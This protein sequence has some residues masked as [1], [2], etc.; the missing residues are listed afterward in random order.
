MLFLA[1]A[2]QRR[3]ELLDLMQITHKVIPQDFDE[4]SIQSQDPIEC[5]QQIVKGKNISARELL[6]NNDEDTPIMTADTLVFTPSNKIV[7]KPKDHDH[8]RKMLN[9]FSNQ[10]HS[11]FSTVMISNSEK[12]LI[13]TCK[14]LVTF[15]ELSED[16][17]EE[18]S[19]ISSS[20]SSLNVTSVL[21]V[22]IN[23]FS[24]LLII[25][26]EKTLCV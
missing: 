7:G 20:L 10:T 15:K 17:I 11:V 9:E 22:V 23:D 12:S 14:T 2:S 26:V 16:E 24:E 6:K 8:S 1:S 5:S 3:T 4:D 18:Y 19:S 25:T 21:H 13:T